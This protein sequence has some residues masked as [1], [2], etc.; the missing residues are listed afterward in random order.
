M[1]FVRGTVKSVAVISRAKFIDDIRRCSLYSRASRLSGRICCVSEG[2][3]FHSNR[4]RAYDFFPDRNTRAVLSA[5]S[6]VVMQYAESDTL[7]LFMYAP[8][9]S[10]VRRAADRLVAIFVAVIT[11]TRGRPSPASDSREN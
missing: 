1:A 2:T 7:T 10:I 4:A 11:S 6:V 9:C 8:P 5:K 3:A